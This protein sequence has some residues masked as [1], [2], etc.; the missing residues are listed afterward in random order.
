MMEIL[1][2]EKSSNLIKYSYVF[3]PQSINKNGDKV[4]VNRE[5]KLRGLNPRVP[6]AMH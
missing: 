4:I 3:E 6:V 5:V 1:L 2:H